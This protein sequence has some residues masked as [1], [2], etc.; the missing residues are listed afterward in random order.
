MCKVILPD[1]NKKDANFQWAENLIA[2]DIIKTTFF[3][4]VLHYFGAFKNT[5]TLLNWQPISQVKTQKEL[6]ELV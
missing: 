3:V 1:Q 4:V 2:I 5:Q 6:G